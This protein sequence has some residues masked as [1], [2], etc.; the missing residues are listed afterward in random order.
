MVSFYQRLQGV[1]GSAHEVIGFVMV[2]HTYFTYLVWCLLPFCSSLPSSGT[3]S[4][5]LASQGILF[6]L[7]CMCI[8]PRPPS[9]ILQASCPPYEPSSNFVAFAHTHTHNYTHIKIQCWTLHTREHVWYSESRA[10]T[11]NTQFLSWCNAVLSFNLLFGFILYAKYNT[12]YDL[13]LRLQF[14]KCF[15]NYYHTIY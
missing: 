11:Y 12:I 5:T 3:S 4:W 1:R 14:E 6:P 13:C 15:A 10:L 8:V 2:F 7:P 9:L